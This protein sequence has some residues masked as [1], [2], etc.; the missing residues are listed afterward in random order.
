MSL[1]SRISKSI[2]G[3]TIKTTYSSYKTVR[4]YEGEN[5]IGATKLNN[6]KVHLVEDNIKALSPFP[7]AVVAR[8]L[9]DG[10]VTTNEYIIYVN[11]EW[12]CLERHIKKAILAHELGHIKEGH[13]ERSQ[14]ELIISN[15]GRVFGSTSSLKRELEAD[16]AAAK[17]GLAMPLYRFLAMIEE[18]NPSKE[19]QIRKEELRKQF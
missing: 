10:K 4:D 17:Q 15:I 14:Q 18:K 19:I 11:K 12:S 7:N 9:V 8:A 2:V 6:A 16:S 5:Y 1:V 3:R 13:L